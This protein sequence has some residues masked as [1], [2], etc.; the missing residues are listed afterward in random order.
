MRVPGYSKSP[1]R[2]MAQDIVDL[3][4]EL[5]ADAQVLDSHLIQRG[6]KPTEIK[7]HESAARALAERT[8]NKRAA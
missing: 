5:G 7:A 4:K 6:W 1:A 8:L 2:L 3:A